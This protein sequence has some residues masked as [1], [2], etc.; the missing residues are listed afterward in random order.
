MN[1]TQAKTALRKLYGAKA[2]WR[3]SEKAPKA[4]ERETLLAQLPKLQNTA[5]MLKHQVMQRR[6]E[7][8]KD[9]EY[10]ALHQQWETA[11]KATDKAMARLHSY[12]VSVGCVG[13]EI[14]GF[15]FFHV[16]AEGDNWQEAIDKARA[17]RVKP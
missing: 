3:Y 10:L 9:T 7:L 1:V 11:R 14:N 13:G 17:K 4:E 12:R 6:E 5:E 16:E 15:S 8:L 2:A